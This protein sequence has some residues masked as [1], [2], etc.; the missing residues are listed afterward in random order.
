[1]SALGQKR[2]FALLDHFVGAKE[3]RLRGRQ[4]ERL[5]SGQHPLF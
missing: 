1:M 3:E 4:A 2:T 5:G